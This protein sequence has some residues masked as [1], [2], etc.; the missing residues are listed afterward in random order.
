MILRG[1]SR[2]QSGVPLAAALCRQCLL[3][4]ASKDKEHW[5]AKTHASGTQRRPPLTVFF[6]F[7]ELLLKKLR[8]PITFGLL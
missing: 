3:A 1:L 6:L 2:L 5:R 8:S 7:K 4:L